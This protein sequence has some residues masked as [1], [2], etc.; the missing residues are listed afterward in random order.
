[1]PT[2]ESCAATKIAALSWLQE[3]RCQAKVIVDANSAVSKPG[4][5]ER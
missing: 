3:R 1:M 4:K 5:K 2:P